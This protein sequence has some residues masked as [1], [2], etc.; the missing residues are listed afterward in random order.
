MNPGSSDTSR[1]G[2]PDFH[3][4][5]KGSNVYR[6]YFVGLYTTPKGS[7]PSYV[8]FFYKYQIPSGLFLESIEFNIKKGL[9]EL[10]EFV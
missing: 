10:K 3:A 7:H 1:I 4:T 9:A 8:I 5:L 6:N 2:D